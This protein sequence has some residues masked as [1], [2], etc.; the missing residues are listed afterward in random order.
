M[1][2]TFAYWAELQ[3]ND[4]SLVTV[5][6]EER[7][8]AEP[9][10]LGQ[11]RVFTLVP[12]DINTRWPVVRIHIPDDAKPI[13]KTR[14]NSRLMGPSVQSG[15]GEPIFRAYA[16]GWFKDSQSH[17]TWV[18]PNGAIET[19]T[20]DPTFNDILVK[21]ANDLSAAGRATGSNG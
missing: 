4:G 7:G 21:S 11:T 2:D 8:W 13:F 9:E 6:L 10:R 17:W 20:D 14:M 16:V 1:S 3:L 19:E 5:D 18:F 12:K 15:M